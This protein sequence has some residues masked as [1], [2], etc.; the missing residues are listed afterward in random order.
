MRFIFIII[1]TV[2]LFNFCAAQL[3]MD[4]SAS[5]AGSYATLR[6]DELKSF[7]KQT[8]D[9]V[10]NSEIN[11]SPFWLDKWNSAL[12]YTSTYKVL[13]PKTKLNLYTND[14][15]YINKD[16]Q[17]LSAS[18]GQIKRI[19]FFKA[20]D[21]SVV[22]GSFIYMKNPDDNKYH[23]HQVLING[24]AE[25][26]KLNTVSVR[27][28]AYDPLSGKSDFNY[29]TKS[30]YYLYYNGNM[31]QLKMLNKESIFAIL[32]AR[33]WGRRMACKK[34]KQIKNRN[35]YCTVSLLL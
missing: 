32:K 14:I 21:T 6:F 2:S 16:G 5:S 23:F 17:T 12:L 19:T 26:I 27:K 13:V 31:Q 24:K 1:F 3:D 8:V 20:D 33:H 11:G 15:Y 7:G 9:E 18:E 35:R 25:L 10:E 28:S 22:L 34:Q 30:A 29:L 4:I